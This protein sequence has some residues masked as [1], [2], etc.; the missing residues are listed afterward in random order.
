M[1]WDEIYLWQL[2]QP[3]LDTEKEE[4][5]DFKRHPNASL[6]VIA[7]RSVARDLL[8]PSNRFSTSS[9]SGDYSFHLSEY[10]HY[11][12]EFAKEQTVISVDTDGDELYEVEEERKLLI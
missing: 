5:D 4:G 6:A 8:W 2:I 12:A 11:D 9:E 7:R 3:S 1:S 10:E